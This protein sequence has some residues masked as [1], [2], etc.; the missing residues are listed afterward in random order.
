VPDEAVDDEVDGRVD[1]HEEV[2]E[3]HEDLG[4]TNAMILK[5]FEL[6]CK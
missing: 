3:E 5:M 1:D 4:G 2:R 6:A